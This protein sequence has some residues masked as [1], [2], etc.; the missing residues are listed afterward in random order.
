MKHTLLNLF[1]LDALFCGQPNKLTSSS[2]LHAVL[3]VLCFYFRQA[4]AHKAVVT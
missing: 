4:I 2:F 1:G 3:I